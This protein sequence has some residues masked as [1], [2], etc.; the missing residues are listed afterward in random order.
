[1]DKLMPL[2]P[3]LGNSPAKYEI[4]KLEVTDTQINKLN[5]VVKAHVEKN[6]TIDKY[7]NI[8]DSRDMLFELS[9]NSNN[10]WKIYRMSTISTPQN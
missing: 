10:Q 8:S 3:A 1:M 2:I 6:I 7:G 5:A 9:K 4:K